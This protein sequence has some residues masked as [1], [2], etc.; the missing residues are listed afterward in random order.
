[1]VHA[2]KP[3]V[4][5]LFY[6]A[7]E[8]ALLSAVTALMAEAETAPAKQP[9]KALIVPHAGYV[10]SGAMAAK[11][12]A[13]LKEAKGKI[14]RVILLGPAHTVYL[15]GM[16]V[17]EADCFEMPLATHPVDADLK[18]RALQLPAVIADDQPHLSEHA[19]EVQLPFIGETLGEVRIL[20]VVVGDATGEDVARL[21]E[22]L[23]D[24][25]ETLVLISSD[26]SHYYPYDVARKKDGATARAIEQL[27]P[28]AL[29]N[30]KAC[31]FRA[32][33]GLLLVARDNALSVQRL[34]LCNSGD[35]AGERIKVV[36]YGAWGFWQPWQN[37]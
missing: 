31:G 22:T 6:P 15:R 13:T 35:T 29:S 30:D 33:Q 28:G 36:G 34:G 27:N 23:W 25:P 4:A 1:M 37:L 24:G 12:Y 19:L 2:R 5:G 17:P 9:P 16:A 18:R 26:L 7:E 11:G 14:K 21:I 10:Y 20:P 3:A 8:G 32:I